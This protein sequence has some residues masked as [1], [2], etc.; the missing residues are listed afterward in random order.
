M[1]TAL[2]AA[3]VW[4]FDLDNTLYPASCGLFAG[5]SRRIGLFVADR[6][7]LAWEEAQALQRRYRRDYGTTLRG[8]MVE[9]AVDPEPFMDFVHAVDLTPI[10]PAPALDRAL[11]ALPGR[12]LV[13]TNGSRAHAARVLDRLGVAGRFDGVFDIGDAGYRPKPDSQAYGMLIERFGVDP[14]R[15]VMVEDLLCNL[16]PARALGMTTVWVTDDPAAGP[17]AAAADIA[18]G[19]LAG[20][21]AGLTA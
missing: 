8:L 1:K 10:P 6:L 18:I 12:K 4:I 11:A 15:A 7:G 19:D 3:E 20:W 2:S 13:F 21:L 17:V 5:I 14:A 16:V 9:H